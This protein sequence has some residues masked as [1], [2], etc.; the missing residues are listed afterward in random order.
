VRPARFLKLA[1]AEVEEAV[2]FFDRQVAGLGDRFQREVEITV[3][4]ITEHPEIGS[5][6]TKRTRKFRIRKF[7]YNVVY[8]A[9]DEEIVIIAVAHHKRR[10]RYWRRRI[11]GV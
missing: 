11:G 6:L 1:E 5:P 4:H 8:V 3:A 9:D 7:N 2:G 10:P